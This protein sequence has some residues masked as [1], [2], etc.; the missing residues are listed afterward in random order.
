M[1]SNGKTVINNIIASPIFQSGVDFTQGGTDLGNTQYIDAFQRG[2]FWSVVSTNSSYHVLLGKPQVLPE[3]TITVSN[4][5]LG[6]V[7]TNPFGSGIIGTY[8]INAFDSQLQTWMAAQK[9]INPGVLPI[10]ITY[11]V[12]LTSGGGC[13]GGYHNANGVQ[14]GGQ[15]YSHATYE[16]SPGMS[17]RIKCNTVQRCCHGK[18]TV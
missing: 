4:P 18:K 1:L 8:D 15:T 11:D 10:F 14:P 17:S 6:S 2:N 13:I 16:D 9:K 5:S 7:F 12:Y 3:K